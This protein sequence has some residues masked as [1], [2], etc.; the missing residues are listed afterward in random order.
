MCHLDGQSF[1]PHPA[2]E[3]ETLL[4]IHRIGLTYGNASLFYVNSDSVMKKGKIDVQLLAYNH[5]IKKASHE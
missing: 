3:K 1:F 5:H 4:R 2:I